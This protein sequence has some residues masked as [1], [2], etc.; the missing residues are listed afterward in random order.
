MVVVVE[1]DLGREYEFINGYGEMVVTRYILSIYGHLRASQNRGGT[2]T[3][4][5]VGSKVTKNTIIGYV[6]DDAHNGDGAEH[7]HLGIRLSYATTAKAKDPAAWF[8]GYEKSTTF[9]ADFATPSIVIRLLQ[10]S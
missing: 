7:L 6:N 3:G 8:R 4:L 5:K 9:G 1:H 2:P 10:S